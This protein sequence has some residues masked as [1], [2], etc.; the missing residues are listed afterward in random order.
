MEKDT[1]QSALAVILDGDFAATSKALLATLGYQSGRTLELS[2]TVDDFIDD[3][4]AL[5]PN[6][7]SERAFRDAAASVQLLLQLQVTRSP[8][9]RNRR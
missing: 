3:F 9:I 1:I 6:T 8:G 4:P 2:G 5:N 7:T